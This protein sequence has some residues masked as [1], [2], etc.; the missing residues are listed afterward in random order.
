MMIV[1]DD[2]A[3]TVKYIWDYLDM[4]VIGGKMDIVDDLRK[5][6]YEEERQY[7][8]EARLEL[9][10]MLDKAADTIE[11][12]RK[13]RNEILEEAALDAEGFGGSANDA[14]NYWAREIS[15]SIRELKEKE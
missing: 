14:K 10:N 5:D 11:R 13:S 3:G 1:I 4:I 12:L 7:K 6:P 9:G 15:E 2:A 8:R